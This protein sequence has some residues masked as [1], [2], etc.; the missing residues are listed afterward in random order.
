MKICGVISMTIFDSQYTSFSS[1]LIETAEYLFLIRELEVAQ[2]EFV[3]PSAVE[4]IH[5]HSS[6]RGFVIWGEKYIKTEFPLIQFS[7]TVLL[8][9]AKAKKGPRN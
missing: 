3:S 5:L 6:V 7:I 8:K 1:I 9:R 2:V 4:N